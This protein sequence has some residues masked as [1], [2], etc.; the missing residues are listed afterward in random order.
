[1]ATAAP[2]ATEDYTISADIPSARALGHARQLSEESE[3]PLAAIDPAAGT[4]G[5]SSRQTQARHMRF[6]SHG[7]NDPLDMDEPQQMSALTDAFA[8]VD[9]GGPAAQQQQQQPAAEVEQL[10]V[11]TYMKKDTIRFEHAGRKF[12]TRPDQ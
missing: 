3:D 1:M 11:G 12:K 9:I 10:L 8:Q 6:R 2:Y 4:T 5:A 7:S